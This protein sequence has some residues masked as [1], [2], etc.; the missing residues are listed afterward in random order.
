MSIL[1]LRVSSL[2]NECEDCQTKGI[3]TLSLCGRERVAHALYCY[4]DTFDIAGRRK[5]KMAL[6]LCL[7]QWHNEDKLVPSGGRGAQSLPALLCSRS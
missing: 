2:C 3:N 6:L 4:P 1:Y 7:W 5:Q